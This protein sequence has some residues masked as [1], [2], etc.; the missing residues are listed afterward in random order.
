[1]DAGSDRPLGERAVQP[2]FA[3]THFCNDAPSYLDDILGG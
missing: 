2:G 3:T 1:M